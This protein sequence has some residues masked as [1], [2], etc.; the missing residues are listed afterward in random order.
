VGT[1]AATNGVEGGRTELVMGKEDHGRRIKVHEEEE[2][3]GRK[4]KIRQLGGP[5]CGRVSPR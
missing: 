5:R 1:A 4:K 2:N 3:R